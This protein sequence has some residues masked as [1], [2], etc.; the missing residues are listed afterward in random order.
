MDEEAKL[1]VKNWFQKEFEWKIEGIELV[2]ELE[3]DT[4]RVSDWFIFYQSLVRFDFC[5]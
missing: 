1:E 2:V 5:C 4:R 3:L